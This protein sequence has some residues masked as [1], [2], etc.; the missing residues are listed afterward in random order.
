MT[1]R[2]ESAV[3]AHEGAQNRPGTF[4]TYSRIPLRTP[5]FEARPD[6]G[7]ATSRRLARALRPVVRAERE[8]VLPVRTTT[9]EPVTASRRRSSE[10]LLQ[11]LRL[12]SFVCRFRMALLLRSRHP[13]S[14]GHQLPIVARSLPAPGKPCRFLPGA[15]RHPR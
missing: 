4:H 7:A 3:A 1:R 14:V 13:W 11:W 5:R 12:P 10:K 8:L 6:G 9:D 2:R 15:E